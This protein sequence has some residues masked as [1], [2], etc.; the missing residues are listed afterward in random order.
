YR[1]AASVRDRRSLSGWLFRVARR[2]A[3]NARRAADRRG[4][5]E[6]A[7]ERPTIESPADLSWR[8]ACSVLHAEIDRLPETYRLPLVLC[9]LRGL[10]RDEAAHRL[11]WSLNEVRGRLERGRSRLRARLQKRGVTLSAGLLA[12][13]VADA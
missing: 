12:A 11:G 1:Q 5:R 9:H 13:V 2:S 7:V 3:A 6:A 4:R 10:S 8:E